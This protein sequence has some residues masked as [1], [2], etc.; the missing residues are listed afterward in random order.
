MGIINA[1]KSEPPMVAFVVVVVV[2]MKVVVKDGAI[3]K[4]NQQNKSGQDKKGQADFVLC[5]RWVANCVP[6]HSPRQR[7]VHRYSLSY[8]CLPGFG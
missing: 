2:A 6:A 1:K 8:H 5:R 3:F 4:I 7:H